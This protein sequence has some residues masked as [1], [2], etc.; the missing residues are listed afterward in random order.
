MVIK[1]LF[2]RVKIFRKNVLKEKEVLGLLES[3][4][5]SPQST[6]ITVHRSR[7]VEVGSIYLHI[8]NQ[9]PVLSFIEW[10]LSIN[11]TNFELRNSCVVNGL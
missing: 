10:V 9:H 7:I 5:T 2:Q 3:M 1:I 8:L 4:S 11:V 6:L